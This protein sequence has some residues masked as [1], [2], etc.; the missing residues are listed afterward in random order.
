MVEH[1]PSIKSVTQVPAANRFHLPSQHTKSGL[2]RKVSTDDSTTQ[3]HLN[4]SPAGT[5]GGP[6]VWG[7]CP[8][9]ILLCPLVAWTHSFFFPFEDKAYDSACTSAKLLPCFG[10]AVT[11]T[12]MIIMFHGGLFF[13]AWGVWSWRV[14]RRWLPYWIC[15]EGQ[16]VGLCWCRLCCVT[17]IW[18]WEKTSSWMAEATDSTRSPSELAAC[19]LFPW[20]PKVRHMKIFIQSL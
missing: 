8:Q 20:L 16:A 1:S 7:L 4:K 12:L 11:L 18:L 15:V 14:V 9:D 3:Y 6:S 5:Y 19:H 2:S 17:L 13:G 10:F